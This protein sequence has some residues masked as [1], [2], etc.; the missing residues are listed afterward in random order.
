MSFR[1]LGWKSIIL[2]SLAI[3]RLVTRGLV[4][5]PVVSLVASPVAWSL[6]AWSLVGSLVAWKN[7]EMWSRVTRGLVT[8]S[9][10]G[11]RKSL[12]GIRLVGC[13]RV[14]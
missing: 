2:R 11:V 12:V 9:R 6:E 4:G 13:S 8:G 1:S 14:T 3:G 7:I 5:K 10:P